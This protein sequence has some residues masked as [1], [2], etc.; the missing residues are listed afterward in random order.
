M[1][2]SLANSVA[3]HLRQRYPGPVLVCGH[4]TGG[5]VA[6]QLAVTEPDLVAGLVLVNTGRGDDLRAAVLDRSCATPLDPTERARMLV[7]SGTV[8]QEAVREVLASQRSLDFTAVLGRIAAPT[9]VLHGELDRALRRR[10][11][12]ARRGHP[13]CTTPA[14]D[15]R[16]HPGVRGARGGRSRGPGAA[17]LLLSF[18]ECL[19]CSSSRPAA[20]PDRTGLAGAALTD[21]V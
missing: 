14:G 17:P 5:A 4:S 11:P 10:G 16:A 18:H 9:I 3:E 15:R 7:W 13:L 1:G 6:L 8:R 2:P 19:A 21:V 12:R 20:P